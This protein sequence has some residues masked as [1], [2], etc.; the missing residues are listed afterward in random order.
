MTDEISKIYNNNAVS[1]KEYTDLR[2][3]DTVTASN[4]RFDAQQLA[5]KDALIS[6]EKAVAAALDSTKEAIG[7]AEIAT[8]KRFDLLSEKID[9]V[10]DVLNK[11]VGAQGVYV[12]HTDLTAA[13]D[14]L[15]TSIEITLRPVVTFMNSQTGKD[16]GASNKSNSIVQGI[17]TG[18]VILGIFGTIITFVIK[19]I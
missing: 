7:K 3:N 15:Q 13:L 2:I 11:N 1:L 16:I 4:Q 6:Q 9:G 19:F 17:V 12:T 10:H 14:K 18:S 8:D 5:L